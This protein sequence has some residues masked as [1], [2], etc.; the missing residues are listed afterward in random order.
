MSTGISLAEMQH[1]G[2][3]HMDAH[4]VNNCPFNHP[5]LLKELN[6]NIW[7][8]YTSFKHPPMS[9]DGFLHNLCHSW[10]QGPADKGQPPHS[11]SS[12]SGPVL[13]SVLL[14]FLSGFCSL[15]FQ[16]PTFPERCFPIEKSQ[17]FP[18]GIIFN[19]TSN[20]PTKPLTSQL[21]GLTLTLLHNRKMRV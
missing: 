16:A 7:Y 3:V 21:V 13:L 5:V 11:R 19:Q 2:R 20:Q 12:L 15:D 4:R 6:N 10:R 18:W 8:Y 1:Q 17:C 9:P 14:I